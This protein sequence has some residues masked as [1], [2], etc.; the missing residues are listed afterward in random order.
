MNA[1][2]EGDGS[3]TGQ[4]ESEWR[5]RFLVTPSTDPDVRPYRSRLLPWVTTP[6]RARG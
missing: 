6:K 4:R 1:G 5:S 2:L 3:S